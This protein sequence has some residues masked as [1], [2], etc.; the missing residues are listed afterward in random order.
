MVIWMGLFDGIRWFCDIFE[1]MGDLAVDYII[2]QNRSINL[3]VVNWL[4][5]V[6]NKIMLLNNRA[7]V[8][9]DRLRLKVN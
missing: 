9:M 7:T 2:V 8:N 1:I 4:T 6:I 3:L 5:I